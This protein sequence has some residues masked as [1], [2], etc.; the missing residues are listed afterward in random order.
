MN[1]EE[2]EP[3]ALETVRLA[4]EL[5]A[6][7]RPVVGIDLSGNPSKGSLDNFGPGTFRD[8]EGKENYGNLT[9]YFFL[10]LPF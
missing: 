1:R 6:A 2:S 8:E 3:N 9:I 5:R 7:G 4:G 10:F